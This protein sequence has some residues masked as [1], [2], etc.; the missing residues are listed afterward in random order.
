MPMRTAWEGSLGAWQSQGFSLNCNYFL[1]KKLQLKEK[2]KRGLRG[3]PPQVSIFQNENG[4]TCYT[5]NKNGARMDY[6][7]I[8]NQY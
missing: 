6:R 3:T 8:L 2:L 7:T 5:I 4:I 1:S